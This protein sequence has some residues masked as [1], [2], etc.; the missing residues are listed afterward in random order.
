VLSSRTALAQRVA[1]DDEKQ[2]PTA[3]RLLSYGSKRL[4]CRKIA[5][6]PTGESVF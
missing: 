3:R 2:A 1:L 5:P 6:V 4:D